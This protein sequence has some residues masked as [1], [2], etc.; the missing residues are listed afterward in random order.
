MNIK[1]NGINLNN[2]A[3]SGHKKFTDKTGYE[4]HKFYYL[5]DSQ[6]YDCELELYNIRRDKNGNLTIAEKDA[7]AKILKMDGGMIEQDM[8]EVDEIDPKLGFAYRFKLTDKKTKKFTY[9]FDNGTVIGIFNQNAGNQYN[10]VLNN[11]ATINK[12]GPMQLIMPDLYYPGMEKSV[13][14]TEALR[15]TALTKLDTEK[16]N[17][18]LNSVRTHANKLGGN[19]YGIISRLKEIS[20]QEGIKR[21]VGTPYT[22]DSISSHKYWTENAYQ[23]SPDFGTEEDFKVFQ[24][25][26]FKNDINWV[27]D[28]ALVNEGYGGIHMA[29]LLRKGE[30]SV[31]KNMFR[32]GELV[33]LG[34][35]PD[36][37]EHT[38]MKMINAPVVLNDQNE[39]I[40]N[41]HY[42]SKKPTYIQ[43]YDDRLV[44]EKQKNSQSPSALITYDKK[45]TDNIYDITHH[46]DAVYPFPIEVSPVELEN[47]IK[48]IAKEN[49]GKVD[50]SDTSIIKQAANFSTFNVVNKSNAGG[51]EFWD[52]NVDIAKLMFYPCLKD[53]E[54]F[55]KL[56]AYEKAE[57]VADFNAGAMAVREYAINAGKYW[58]KSCADELLDYTS[59]L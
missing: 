38:N 25:E 35:L 44:S 6:K 5:Y 10:V 15:G 16:R 51:I 39:V 20:Q 53:D 54:R 21:I 28:A 34:I 2:V 19:F 23:I 46:D 14:P 52:G 17:T 55:V 8:S 56:P 1:N 36:K 11:R 12:N 57:A 37:S 24:R 42:D 41:P 33:S 29:E 48:R 18:A 45:N 4:K 31:S 40:K 59:G 30:N 58:T 47:N 7:P 32:T 50:L 49:D 13:S 26:L 3:F 9:A 22:K 43:F 27:A